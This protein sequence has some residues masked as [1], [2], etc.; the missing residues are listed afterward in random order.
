MDETGVETLKGGFPWRGAHT[1]IWIACVV[2]WEIRQLNVNY[3]QCKT[4]RVF[5]KA[6]IKV[7]L[8]Q[9]CSYPSP[10]LGNWVRS[11]AHAKP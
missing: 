8:R 1:R 5:K 10:T 3:V 11:T 9:G 2:T 4:V 7:L 6:A